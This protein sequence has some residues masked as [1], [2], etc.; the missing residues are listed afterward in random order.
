MAGFTCEGLS[1]K[2]CCGSPHARRDEGPDAT[3]GSIRDLAAGQSTASRTQNARPAD[4]R[5][6]RT[7]QQAVRCAAAAALCGW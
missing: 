6:R 5:A 7:A 4:E 3:G 2:Q 1:T